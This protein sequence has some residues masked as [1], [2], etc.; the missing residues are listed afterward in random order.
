MFRT[1]R[2]V[3]VLLTLGCQAVFAQ[4]N[5]IGVPIPALNNAP[6]ALD[7]HQIPI[8]LNSNEAREPL[9]DATKFGIKT[10]SYYA[11]KFPSALDKVLVRRSV[12][13]KLEKVNSFLKPSGVEV[14]ILDGYRPVELQRELWQ[15]FIAKA[16]SILPNPTEE[17]CIEFAGR[18]CS[19]P[20]KFNRDDWRTWPT[21]N[22]GGA[23]DV[24]LQEIGTGRQLNM[25]GAF[26][27]ASEVSYTDH[28][29]HGIAST[30]A[31]EA[32]KN[33]RLLYGA[34]TA[35]GFANYPYEWWHFDY[36]SQMWV[37]NAHKHQHA[38]YGRAEIHSSSTTSTTK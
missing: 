27:D 16:K 9:V 10:K 15:H 37:M 4:S 38:K 12:A 32:R 6:T 28:Y 20:R 34:M 22:T 33:R 36:G 35:A 8:D 25:G 7:Y 26:D 21:H 18:F 3:A 2:A 31:E 11:H 14:V 30:Y 23:V 5:W 17:Q 29:E 19:D 13:G 24:T 1:K